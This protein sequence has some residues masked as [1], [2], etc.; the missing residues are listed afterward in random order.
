MQP[1]IETL[2]QLYDKLIPKTKEAVLVVM[3]LKRKIEEGYLE[4]E[5][6]QNDFKEALNEVVKANPNK[7][8]PQ[9]ERIS[10]ELSHYYIQSTKDS[11]FQLLTLTEYAKDVYTLLTNR[12]ENQLSKQS[13]LTKVNDTIALEE[14]YVHNI[15]DIEYWYRFKFKASSRSIILAHIDELQRTVD[16]EVNKL[17][18][19]L[20]AE[21]TALKELIERFLS[22]FYV[23]SIKAEEI[24]QTLTFKE[25]LMIKLRN[26][27]SKFI[28]SQAEA[29][30][31]DKIEADVRI[32]FDKIDRR[33]SAINDKILQ[34]R[35]RLRTF[36]QNFQYQ[37]R[38]KQ[39]IDNFL[40]HLITHSTYDKG[41]ISTP[42]TLE[43]Q[44]I[45]YERYRLVTLP[46]V[47]LFLEDAT[48]VNFEQADQDYLNKQK[49]I[50][51]NAF[52]WQDKMDI[53]LAELEASLQ[54]NGFL[55]LEECFIKVYE[56]EKNYEV[57]VQT[58]FN[59]LQRLEKNKNVNIQKDK[60]EYLSLANDVI[61]WK[62]K[63][64]V[65]T[66]S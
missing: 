38:Q 17:R 50:Q 26:L 47:S 29:E 1:F 10:K 49:Q 42:D 51:M 53:W 20:L 32:F 30:S 58:L 65:T 43:V 62:A 25:S 8:A 37:N 46:I 11:G 63:A 4:E 9:L 41:K 33:I 56:E 18:I 3:L 22:S 27:R 52:V 16:E 13:F 31:F 60:N 28:N 7:E 61:I 2:S 59:L 54:T 44:H 66:N 21:N 24:T 45:P 55:A 36:Y 64:S 5:F 40:Q 48:A 19:I 34:S 35:N 6:T 12:I 57:A 14:G 23:I 39:Q 15:D